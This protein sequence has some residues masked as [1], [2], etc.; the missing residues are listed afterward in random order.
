MKYH[1]FKHLHTI[2]KHRFHVF[3]NCT[4]CGFF[5]QGLIHDLSK[6]SFKEFIPSCKYYQG[7]ASPVFEERFHDGL[8]SKIA[9]HHT[10]RNRHHFEY[11][12]DEFMGDI[13]L[14]KMP[15]KYAVEY[16]C[17]VIAAS[18]VYNNKK[19]TTNLP[20]D[21]F[22]SRCDHYL[23]HPMTKEFVKELLLSYSKEGFKALKKKK[24]KLIYSILDKNYSDTVRIDFYSKLN[25]FEGKE[26]PKNRVKDPSKY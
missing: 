11:W 5:F 24:T 2:N 19:Y 7:Y 17:D 9:I 14:I 15:Y 1:V 26:L 6:Y 8:Y 20:Y 21:F 3:L 25:T 10:N 12:V 4:K 18:Q 13:I 23:M 22:S 16:V